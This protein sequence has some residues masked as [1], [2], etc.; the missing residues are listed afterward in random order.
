[1]SKV[2][3]Y[4]GVRNYKNKGHDR[5]YKNDGLCIVGVFDG[6]GGAELSQAV[7]ETLPNSIFR[8]LG[9]RALSETNFLATILHNLDNLEHGS[10]RK[11]TAA[12]A[13]LALKDN[14]YTIAYANAGDSSIYY[15][16][17]EDDNL[18]RLAHT[19][20]SYYKKSGAT[21]IA[22][23]D[24]LGNNRSLQEASQLVGSI[25]A[26]KHSRWSIVGFSDGVQD[27]DG[28]G[29]TRQRLQEILRTSPPLDVPNRI[30][31]DY[32]QYDD[33]SL[34]LIANSGS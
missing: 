30:F 33:S 18:I 27:D 4:G 16:D 31:S 32:E 12:M 22:T 3:L 21:Y 34:F 17:H 24:F 20:T 9:N 13:S 10:V 14:M 28:Q 5:L 23:D 29:I 7:I 11:A 19:P 15:Y 2:Q 1:M 8:A 25:S 26:H 6:A